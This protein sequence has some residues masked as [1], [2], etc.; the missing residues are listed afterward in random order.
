MKNKFPGWFCLK[1]GTAT[2]FAYSIAYCTLVCGS[3]NFPYRHTF[4]LTHQH[5][6][7]CALLVGL[8]PPTAIISSRINSCIALPQTNRVGEC[9]FSAFPIRLQIPLPHFTQL[10][11][12]AL[13][14][15]DSSNQCTLFT[16]RPLGL[17]A[18]LMLNPSGMGALYRMS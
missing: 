6:Y 11:R 13:P 14:A 17:P 16:T 9:F 2:L 10:G 3:N 12:V 1:H 18:E 7:L 4:R 8:N 5:V 15:F